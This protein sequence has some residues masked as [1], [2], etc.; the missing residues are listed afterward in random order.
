MEK[1][2]QSARQ[3]KAD[4]MAVEAIAKYTDLSVVEIGKL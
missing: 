3:M 4:G 2:R 1:W